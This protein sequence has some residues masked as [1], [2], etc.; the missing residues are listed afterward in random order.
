MNTFAQL[1]ADLA[2]MKVRISQDPKELEWLFDH[3]HE[4]G[5]R[6][7]LEVGSRNGGSLYILAHAVANGGKIVAVDLPY[8]PWGTKDSALDLERVRATL[9]KQGY[10]VELILGDSSSPAVV[11]KVHAALPAGVDFVFVDGDHSYTGV[12]ND[13]CNYFELLTDT[14]LM[15]FHD[16]WP[17]PAEPEIEVPKLWAEFAP[18]YSGEIC[19]AHA[20][21]PGIGILHR[22]PPVP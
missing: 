3:A 9:Q 8:G 6:H 15:A 7:M 1:W 17:R 21:S 20:A 22:L 2:A 16:V 12:R 5:A 10:E 19:V 18:R 13:F 11:Q 14:G 4:I